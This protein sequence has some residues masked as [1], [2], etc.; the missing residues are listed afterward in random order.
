MKEESALGARGGSPVCRSL[1]N[2][3][4]S[5]EMLCQIEIVWVF[6]GSIPVLMVLAGCW[7]GTVNPLS[8]GPLVWTGNPS[9]VSGSIPL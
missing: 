5:V 1:L 7:R 6:S 3:T 8:L 9:G 4:S 2:L